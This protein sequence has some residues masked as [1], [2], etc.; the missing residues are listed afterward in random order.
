MDPLISCFIQLTMK[1]YLIRITLKGISMWANIE[2]N[3]K[4]MGLKLIPTTSGISLRKSSP[5]VT[6]KRALTV[7]PLSATSWA[8]INLNTTDT[9]GLKS[10]AAISSLSSKKEA[11]WAK[12]SEWNTEQWSL[13]LEDQETPTSVSR[14]SWAES[15]MTRHSW[16]W[17]VSHDPFISSN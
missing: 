5:W 1:R 12:S 3:W 9:C 2:K 17:M 11:L 10:S 4:K 6:P 7:Q 13:A 8:D 15:Q 16:E 14:S